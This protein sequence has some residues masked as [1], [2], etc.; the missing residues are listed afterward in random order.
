MKSKQP[1][2]SSRPLLGLLLENA[3]ICDAKN[4]GFIAFKST[5]AVCFSLNVII[6]KPGEELKGSHLDYFK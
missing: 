5:E 4:M 6:M 3:S 1:R 2:M